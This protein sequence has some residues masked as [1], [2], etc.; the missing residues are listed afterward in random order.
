MLY[1][2]FFMSVRERLQFT[3]SLDHPVAQK[4]I[5]Q[6]ASVRLPCPK[7]FLQTNPNNKFTPTHLQ[8]LLKKKTHK[9]IIQKAVFIMTINAGPNGPMRLLTPAFG[10]IMKSFKSFK[11]WRTALLACFAWQN[12]TTI[13]GKGSFQKTASNTPSLISRQFCDVLRRHLR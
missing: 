10:T 4:P 12:D 7:N 5:H 2:V 3:V 6:V 11:S 8:Q 13:T 9:V 1:F